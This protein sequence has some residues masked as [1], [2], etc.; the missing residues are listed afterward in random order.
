[1]LK[2]YLMLLILVPLHHCEAGSHDVPSEPDI[3]A[4]YG[5]GTIQISSEIDQAD[6]LQ[7]GVPI[8]GSVVITHS[9][10]K[11]IDSATFRLGDEPLQAWLDKSISLTSDDRV[12]MTVYRFQLKGKDPGTY[13]L[14]SIKV[15]I[16]GKDYL[17][18]SLTITVINAK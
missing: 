4:T 1:M 17:A 15:N 7:A 8:Q 9:I 16:S 10:N 12:L 2:I 11:I 14:P 5:E 6:S 13:T 18:P 3:S